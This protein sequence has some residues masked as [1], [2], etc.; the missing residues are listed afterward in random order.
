MQRRASAFTLW[1]LIFALVISGDFF[2]WNFG[3]DAG[4]FGGMLVA[5][6]LV[7]ILYSGLSFCIAEMSPTM[8]HTGGA[9]SFARSAMGPWGGF[10]TGVA[11]TIEYV[12]ASSV[13]VVGI[14]G[15]MGTI[16][17]DLFDVSL[18]QPLWWAIF[19][20]L[21]VL[22][23]VAGVEI[24]LKF[25]VAI[26]FV[27]IGVLA[28]FWVGA[29]PHFD[30]DNALMAA[31]EDGQPQWFPVGVDGV[32]FALPFAAWFLL[33]VE[34]V[35][36]V[37]EESH[38][39]KRDIPRAIVLALVTLAIAAFLTL[40]LSSGMAPGGAVVGTSAEPLGEGFKTIFGAGTA[41][42]VL[43]LLAVVG[44][45][46]SFHGVIFAYGRNIFSLSRAGYYPHFFSLT[47]GRRHTPY[48]ALIVGSVVG[49][50]LAYLLYEVGTGQVAAALLSMAVFGAVVS[51]V[52]QAAAFIILRRKM[53]HVERPFRSPFGITGAVVTMVLTIMMLVAIFWN[54]DYRPGVVG[55]LVFYLVAVAYFALVGRKRLVL[56]P[57]EEFALTRGEHGH[58]ETEGYGVTERELFRPGE[59]AETTTSTGPQPDS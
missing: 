15:Y 21:F 47:H 41:V 7:L 37:A 26:T 9:Y 39:P 25:A 1:A 10:S 42:S 44:L 56:S 6:V 29:L 53:P 35:P 59:A 58:P 49:Y 28:V 4:G 54:A 43:S 57:E 48:I 30:L 38:E 31:S 17:N 24:A 33:G 16:I 52:A 23:N 34:S 51:Y 2:G 14:G 5:T 20:L 11:E 22:L 46:A 45:V 13:V 55:M 12:V 19:Y 40:F 32:F 36:L 3:L 8:P 27:T 18:S 50:A